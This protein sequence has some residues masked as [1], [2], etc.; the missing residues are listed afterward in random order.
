MADII[1]VLLVD[2]Q[3]SIFEGSLKRV[4]KDAGIELISARAV[5]DPD[6]AIA[7]IR[8]HSHATHILLDGYFNIGDCEK[9]VEQLTE[10]EISKIVCFSGAP[11]DW[12]KKLSFYGVRHYPGKRGDFVSC[13]SG[14][15]SCK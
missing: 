7:L 1:H 10:E 8:E 11:K 13:I 14:A 2:D 6:E 12:M 9:V 3:Y 5:N 15:C 4:L